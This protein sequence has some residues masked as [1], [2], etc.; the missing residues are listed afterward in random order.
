MTADP[1]TKPVRGPITWMAGHSV[2]ANLLM[3]VLLI[4]GV[5]SALRIKQEVF[6][7]FDLDMV[8]VS[9]P[10]PGAS[11]EEIEQGIILAVEE[12]VR[13]LDGV[14]QVTSTAAE[15][16][17]VVSIELLLG[18]DPQQ[19]ASDV[20]NAVDRILSFPAEAEK[21]RVTI[22]VRRLHVVDVIVYGDLS[23][24][25][26]RETT[27][28]VRDRLLQDPGI[29]L[30]ELES[31]RPYEIS[32]E[33]SQETLRAYNLTLND[34]AA[35]VRRSSVELPGGGIK[36]EGGEILLRMAERR[37]YGQ[38]FRNIA[39]VT[40]PDGTEVKLG[41]IAHIRDG[42]EDVDVE[43]TYNGHPAMTIRV[44]RVGTET[45]LKVAN[46]VQRYVTDLREIL[47]P[48]VSL[49]T[50]ND[51]SVIYRQRM[52]LLL[53]NA[54]IGL[55]LVLGLL[56]VFLEARLAFWVTMGIPIS[57]LGGL[58]LLPLMGVSI[59]MVSLFAF[60][61]ALGI[62]VDDAIVVGEN[63]YEYHQR[64]IPFG[65]AA[66]RAARDVALPV[67]FSILTNVV[68]FM[69]MF[70][71]PGVMG[72]IFR[73]IPAVVVLVFLISLVESLFILPAHLAHQ[74][75]R[76]RH[77]IRGWLHER[78]QR[79]SHWF[80]HL[81]ND[82]YGPFLE[83][84]LHHRYLTVAAGIMI[85]A[86]T[87]GFIRSGRM[88]L[89]MF[90]RVDADI[91]IATANLPY[92]SS[93]ERTRK[94]QQALLDA[95]LRVAESVGHDRQVIGFKTTI[96]E[97]QDDGV[98]IAGDG[99]AGGHIANV[100]FLLTDPD[101]RVLNTEQFIKR[102]REETGAVTGLDSLVFLSDAG[103]PGAG[104]SLTVDLSHRSLDVLETASA[105]LAE[106]LRYFPNVKDID[107]GFSPGKRQVDFTIRPEGEAL[108][109]TALDVARQVRDAF[110][111]AE[112]TRQQRGRNEMKIMV[113]L[114]E[115]QRVSEYNLEEFII[116]AA[117]GREA[118]LRDLVDMD[119]GRAY[120]V[121]SRRDG[122]RVVSVTADVD[123]PSQAN[124]VLDVVK[125]DALPS[126]VN[127]Y[128][129]LS[130]SFEGKQADMKES[131]QSLMI[132]FVFA[133][134]IVYALLA[135]PFRSYVQPLIIMVCIPFGL[136][137]AVLG[138]IVMGYSLSIMSM[139]GL[140]ALSGVVVND[141]L[142]LIEFANR[143]RRD[144]QGAFKAVR[145]AGVR[146]F[147]PIMLTTL[148]TFGGLAPMMFEQSR[149]A[150]FLIPMALSL[151]YGILFATLI[152]LILVP[153]L[154]VILEDVRQLRRR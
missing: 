126:L 30:V 63:I 33:I 138:H 34:V 9:V 36:T 11:P 35:K 132:G 84:A 44:Y 128:P 121:I 18:A 55:V 1:E 27:E 100:E 59:N 43:S 96:G 64:G 92:G 74:R 152:T 129:G 70:F 123:P 42:F 137:G 102:W 89:T 119:R 5:I 2:A 68:A 95:G 105:E 7:E 76:T 120:T 40:R 122:R 32:I 78:Q 149:Q 15:G 124:Q 139:F 52:N 53:R 16:I 71:V 50:W 65:K 13:G 141:S 60:I 75:D 116:R 46:T 41:D 29:T 8:Q 136:V 115:T 61:V 130:F 144:G 21:P 58:L 67:T 90:P 6:P 118:M 51:T 31:V 73:V 85:L 69:P 4:G 48:G 154:Y 82:R 54:A 99:G 143:K 103:G 107:D 80:S 45:P 97:V 57:F 147:R 24:S 108:G 22:P 131:I 114:P 49:A 83:A 150:R 19:A 145:E 98:L 77:G 113:R 10:Y 12:E 56:S 26:L 3:A 86:L 142:I 72:K 140:V 14:E 47:P 20:Q 153:S 148:T 125:T 111:G 28:Q 109:L 88:G 87:I 133:M 93:I 23:E 38:E 81:I 146:R 66:A 135:I 94:V 25:A 101:T 39:V 110:Y 37:D 91:A 104:A 79:F 62:V 112:V 17:G 127:S 151:G 106:A 117:D 134:M